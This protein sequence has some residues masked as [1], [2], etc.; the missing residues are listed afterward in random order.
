[1]LAI[2]KVMDL[3]RHFLDEVLLF[4]DDRSRSAQSEPGQSLLGRQF[5]IPVQQIEADHGARLCQSIFAVDCNRATL[6]DLLL[7]KSDEIHDACFERITK[8]CA[9]HINYLYVLILKDGL[10]VV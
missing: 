2:D 9:P 7:A 1:M 8:R 4:A 10:I 6:F 3:R 5:S